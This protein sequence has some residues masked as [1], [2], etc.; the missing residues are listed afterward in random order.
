MKTV[1]TFTNGDHDV[2][3][4]QRANGKFRI[5][6]GKEVHDRLNYDEAARE[7]GYCV[8]HSLACASKLED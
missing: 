6:Y 2:K 7:Y 4:E 1:H 8:F 5:T 3:L